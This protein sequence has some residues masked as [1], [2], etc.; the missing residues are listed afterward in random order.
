MSR[1]TEKLIEPW[2]SVLIPLT[3]LLPALIWTLV[4]RAPFSGDESVYARASLE[5][6]R[7]LLRSPTDWPGLVLSIYP[8]K[9]NALIW[10]GQAFVPA[11]HLLGS[12][13]TG[14]LLSVWIANC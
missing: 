3:L 10:I 5:L 8:W 9:P 7:T 14:L 11:G 4:N 2:L 12:V 13:D 6:F 1:R